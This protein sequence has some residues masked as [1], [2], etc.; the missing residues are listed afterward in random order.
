MNT[1]DKMLKKKRPV[2]RLLAVDMDGT[3]LDR[4]SHMSGEI[5]E[6]LREAY[7]MG[8][9]VVPTTGRNLRCLPHRLA[10]KQDIYRYV[11]SSNGAVVTDCRTGKD[12]YRSMVPKETALELLRD[13]GK[14]WVGI[15]TH[16]RHEYLIQG[17]SLVLLGRML[18]GK[19]ARGVYY[20]S[21]ME[22]AVEKSGC[23][24]EELQFYFLMPGARERL[25]KILR[26]YPSLRWACTSIYAEVFSG[27][28]SKGRALCVVAG[29][30]GIGREEIACIGDG[31]N[32]LSMF[33]AAGFRM[34]MGNA[35]PELKER[36]DIILPSNSR[37]GAAKGI[38]LCLP[39]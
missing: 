10:G 26:R 24:V 37:K 12:L 3:C 9:T 31:E 15:T 35:V 19:D 22:R 28:A 4:R 18:Y 13:C 5:I 23:G 33:R 7:R 6:A 32:D 27:Q 17:R 25:E 2:I 8:I 38:R 16:L 36:A 11:I 21:S 29:K 20:V 30:L 1:I 39:C 34:A 14:A